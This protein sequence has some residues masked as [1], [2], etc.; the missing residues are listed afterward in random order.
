M[1]SPLSHFSVA[2]LSPLQSLNWKIPLKFIVALIRCFHLSEETE[3]KMRTKSSYLID[4]Q[5]IQLP[6][7]LP[8]IAFGLASQPQRRHNV[9]VNIV[10][11][12]RKY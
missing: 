7:L 2:F 5:H 12:S 10:Q 1:V 6:L 8:T 9:N 4:I 3:K 11:R